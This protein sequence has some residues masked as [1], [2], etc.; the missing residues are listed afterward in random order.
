MKGVFSQ[1]S[2]REAPGSDFYDAA[3]RGPLLVFFLLGFAGMLTLAAPAGTAEEPLATL[4]L[5][6]VQTFLA[7]VRERLHSDD[8]LL[9]Q[10]TF[11]EKQTERRFDSDGNVKKVTTSMYEVYPSPEPGRT[12]RKLVERDSKPLTSEELAKEDEKQRRKRRRRRSNSTARMPPGARR[13]SR[14]GG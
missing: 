12:Y 5:P 7:D 14:N 2:V 10:Y 8:F 9:D 13:R 4:T 6:D 1:E 3:R 11:T